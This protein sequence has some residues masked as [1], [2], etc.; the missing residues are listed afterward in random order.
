MEKLAQRVSS[1]LY[2][3]KCEHSEFKLIYFSGLFAK[4]RARMRT[5]RFCYFASGPRF[6][7]GC[8]QNVGAEPPGAVRAV[9]CPTTNFVGN[10]YII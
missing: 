4:M 8:Q 6:D 10:L 7:L 3:S 2:V 5:I 1:G 9:P